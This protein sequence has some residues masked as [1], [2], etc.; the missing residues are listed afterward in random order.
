M[1]SPGTPGDPHRWLD[2]EAVRVF[3]PRLAGSLC[4]LDPA[5][6][7]GYRARAAA[8]ADSLDA[9]DR[10]ARAALADCPEIPFALTHPAFRALL[11][12]FGRRPVGILQPDPEGEARPRTLGETARALAAEGGGVIFTEPQLAGRTARALAGDTGAR[13]AVLDPLGGEGIPGRSTYLGLL[14]FNLAAAVE[15]FCEPGP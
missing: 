15:A 12:R 10:R 8:L 9:F 1:A 2:L 4:E 3:L 13:V 11:E 5:G 14:A 7:E 6:A